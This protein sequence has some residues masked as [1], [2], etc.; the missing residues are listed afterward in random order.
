MQIS[1]MPALLAA[2]TRATPEAV[3][4]RTLKDIL[5]AGVSGRRDEIVRPKRPKYRGARTL[6]RLKN[7]QYSQG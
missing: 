2:E 7:H 6:S 5:L 4:G 3:S 1:A